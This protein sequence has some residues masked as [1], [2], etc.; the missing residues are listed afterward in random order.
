[1][2]ESFVKMEKW[3]EALVLFERTLDH[4]KAANKSQ[5]EVRKVF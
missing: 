2:A 4:I 1:M 3:A 5:M